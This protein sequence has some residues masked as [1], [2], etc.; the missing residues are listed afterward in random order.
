LRGLGIWQF[1]GR[2]HEGFNG[3]RTELNGKS[4]DGRLEIANWQFDG[5]DG[6]GFFV[7]FNMGY[8]L[9]VSN[10]THKSAT[11]RWNQS[12]LSPVYAEPYSRTAKCS[13]VKSRRDQS[14]QARHYEFQ[15][16]DPCLQTL[17][18]FDERGD[19]FPQLGYRGLEYKGKHI[20]IEGGPYDVDLLLSFVELVD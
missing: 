8:K 5:G 4:L 16:A 11:T 20:H 3:G 18:S 15:L 7:N 12:V 13:S 9:L 2:I 1:N 6:G 17:V 19:L 10:S 14:F